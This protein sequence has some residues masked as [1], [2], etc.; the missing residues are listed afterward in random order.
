MDPRAP[1]NRR[2]PAKKPS[3]LPLLLSIAILCVGSFVGGIWLGRDQPETVAI[4]VPAAPLPV[5]PNITVEVPP[6]PVVEPSR[7]PTGAENLTF[8]DSLA[9]GEQQP[10][11]S[12]INLPPTGTPSAPEGSPGG[13]KAAAEEQPV[14]ST[15]K[16]DPPPAPKAVAPAP[17]AKPVVPAVAAPVEIG[18]YL[19]QAASFAREEDARALYTRLVKKSYPVSLQTAQLGEKGTWHR[20]LVGPFETSAAAERMVLRLQEEE[21]LSAMV[22]K[23]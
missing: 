11:G 14:K 3:R 23:R 9:K 4:E 8:F 22:R 17:P 13:Q 10:L 5:V 16:P 2:R 12:G 15:P 21:K 7:P 19:V 18:S 20:V 1:L 6:Q